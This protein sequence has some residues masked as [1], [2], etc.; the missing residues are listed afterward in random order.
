MQ[1]DKVITVDKR[2]A[3]N[4]PQRRVRRDWF[5]LGGGGLSQ[6]ERDE[7]V[8]LLPCRLLMKQV[9]QSSQVPIKTNARK[10]GMVSHQNNLRAG[11][12]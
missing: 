6:Y 7:E 2:Q 5:R 12:N 4:S 3:M 1:K 8:R 9:L 11:G 10:L